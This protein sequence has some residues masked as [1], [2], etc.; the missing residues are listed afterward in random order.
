MKVKHLFLTI[1]L[2]FSVLASAQNVAKNANLQLKDGPIAEQ[3]E[4]IL[5]NSNKYQDYKVV[6]RVWIEK[7]QKNVADSINA[8]QKEFDAEIAKVATQQAEIDTLKADL[9]AVNQKIDNLNTEKDSISL[10]GLQ[11]SKGTYQAL[12]WGIVGVLAILWLFFAYKFKAS[13]TITKEAKAKLTETENEF[14]EHRKRSLEREQ[15]V[16]RKLQDE[17]NKNKS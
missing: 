6:K 9:A 2:C 4:F 11:L 10:L 13:N 1:T 15:Q 3:F 5:K 8:V 7:L 12:M 14:E 17:I 16:R